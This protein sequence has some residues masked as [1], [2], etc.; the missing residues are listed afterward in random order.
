MWAI[1]PTLEP[2]ARM[3]VVL[4]WSRGGSMGIC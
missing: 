4:W 1:D 2:G 3:V